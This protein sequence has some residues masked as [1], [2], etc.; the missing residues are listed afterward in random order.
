MAHPT[1]GG[2]R[3]SLFNTDFI[4]N[5]KEYDVISM[6]SFCSQ[7]L[8]TGTSPG[9]LTYTKILFTG[10]GEFRTYTHRFNLRDATCLTSRVLG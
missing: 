10:H 2:K 5:C 4:V 6:K 3:K 9:P 8:N 1:R 7:T